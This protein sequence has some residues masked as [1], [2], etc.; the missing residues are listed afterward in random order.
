[1]GCLIY[2]LT[3]RSKVY[4]VHYMTENKCQKKCNL[5]PSTKVCTGCNRTIEEIIDAGNRVKRLRDDGRITGTKA[6]LVIF[7]EWESDTQA[8]DG[9]EAEAQRDALQVDS[10]P[11]DSSEHLS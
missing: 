10:L 11:D 4:I 9:A 5:D 2:L 1:M 3:R 7:D 6:T 8:E